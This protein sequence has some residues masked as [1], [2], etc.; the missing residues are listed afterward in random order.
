MVFIGVRENLTGKQFGD[1]T[2]VEMLWNYQNKRHTYCK[3]IGI[4]KKEY[5]IRQDALIS[6]AT[7]TVRGACSCGT[8]KD[9]SG[10]RF[11]RLV[12]LEATQ[13]RGSNGAV[14]WKC[15]CDCGNTVYQNIGSLKRGHTTS[16]GCA[17]SEY[18][19]SCKNDIIGK[20][21]GLL[22]VISEESP[23]KGRRIVKCLCDCG[24]FHIC[25]VQSLNK[26]ST[27][28]CGC[29]KKSRGEMY[30]ENLLKEFNIYFEKQK[31]FENCKRKK[32]L[33]FDFFLPI[34]NIC[35]EYDGEQHY[36]PIKYWG[37]EENFKEIQLND[38]I[39]NDFCKKNNIRLVRIPYTKSKQEIFEII[40]NLTS[41]ATTT[42]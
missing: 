11:G 33:R 25:S 21:F 7:R 5:I 40:S 36:K 19:N 41:P 32:R 16:C 29:M 1:F 8:L 17:K 15:V 20:K 13:K 24:N 12:A 3:C 14:I 9:I 26:G 34:Q 35:I 31:S 37:G 28:S 2:V 39:K 18:L 4:D 23:K 42:V 38:Q 22:T 10:M 30:V 6:G 27:M